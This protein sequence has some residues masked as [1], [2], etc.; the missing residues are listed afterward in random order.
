M[1]NKL[2]SPHKLERAA[3]VVMKQTKNTPQFAV[4]RFGEIDVQ[5]LQDEWLVEDVLPMRGQIIVI[6]KSGSGKS[7][8]ASDICAA[9]ARNEP[10]CGKEVKGGAVVYVTAEGVK[11]FLKRVV[12]Y[13]QHHNVSPDIPFF[14]ITD[15]PDLGRQDGDCDE[16]V[17]RIREQVAGPLAIVVLDT[18]ARVMVGA[19]ENSARDMMVFV[20]NMEIMGRELNCAVM[21][22]HHVGKDVSK[23][24]RGSTALRA[25][26]D[27]E[28]LVEGLEGERTVTVKKQKDGEAGQFMK[29]ALEKV[30]IMRGNYET[31]SCIVDVTQG[32]QHEQGAKKR[33]TRL[34]GKKKHLLKI[35]RNALAS[36]GRLS[37]GGDDMPIDVTVVRKSDVKTEAIADNFAGSHGAPNSFRAQLSRGL[38]DLAGDGFIGVR[39]DLIW[40]VE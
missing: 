27:T 30:V 16:I 34:M 38:S 40:V 18:V 17:A 3:F 39:N 23:G 2:D 24:A 6:G 15:V 14:I 28:I 36:H 21:G 25:A 13:R 31:T 10:W 37:P 19:E 4:Q 9:V 11:G 26:V 35:I 20:A 33:K 22:V 7:F 12:A 29:F 8:V 32:W 1:L 5:N